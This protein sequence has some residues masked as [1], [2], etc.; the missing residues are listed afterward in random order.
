M[1]V[2]QPALA[3]MISLRSAAHIS[4]EEHSNHPASL[5]RSMESI[6]VRHLTGIIPQAPQP[7]NPALRTTRVIAADLERL[8]RTQARTTH[9]SSANREGHPD[10]VVVG[11][12]FSRSLTGNVIGL[13]L[14]IDAGMHRS[15]CQ[16]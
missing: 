14:S 9:R 1:S 3:D 8:A 5:P 12:C 2:H 11:T 15:V 4:W 7:V 16:V 13:G 6:L 10:R